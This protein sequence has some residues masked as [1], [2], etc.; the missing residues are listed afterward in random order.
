MWPTHPQGVGGGD[1]DDVGVQGLV[2]GH[3]D[4]V[5]GLREGGVALTPDADGDHH[6]AGLRGDA[7][8]GGSHCQL[9]HRPFS[10]L[11][12]KPPPRWTAW[13]GL[14]PRLALS[15]V[16]H[17]FQSATTQTLQSATTHTFQLATT[18][19]K[20]F[21]QLQ[22]KPLSQ[23]K[24]IHKPFS[25]LQHTHKSFSQLQHTHKHF[26]QLQHAIFQSAATLTQTKPNRPFPAR[27]Q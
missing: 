15:A 22:H 10:Q 14:G 11:Q 5:L 25:Q 3:G 24:H 19:H 13:G 17:T 23:L 7:L 9:Q 12:H 16:T 1:L 20:P 8:V 18:Q 4:D 26:S 21:S 27:H 2:L 6:L